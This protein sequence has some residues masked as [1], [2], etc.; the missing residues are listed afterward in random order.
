MLM[1]KLTSA[2][3]FAVAE[4]VSIYLAFSHDL[5]ITKMKLQRL[6]SCYSIIHCCDI[7]MDSHYRTQAIRV[8]SYCSHFIVHAFLSEK[9]LEKNTK[10]I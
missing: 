8:I 1:T 5:R 10:I 3:L 6:Y 9:N 4:N 2:A 7:I